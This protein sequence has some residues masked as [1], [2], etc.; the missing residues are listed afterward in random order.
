LEPGEK[1]R[2]KKDGEKCMKKERVKE[3]EYIREK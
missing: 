1:E 2:K 3:M